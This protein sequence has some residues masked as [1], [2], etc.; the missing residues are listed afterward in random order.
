MIKEHFVGFFKTSSTVAETLCTIILE[1]LDGLGLDYKSKLVGQCYDGAANMSG[2][3]NGLH[4]KIRNKAKKALYVHCYA[5]QLNLALQHSCIAIKPAR[6]CLDT[7][8]SLHSFIECSSK[9]HALFELI[10][11][12][13]LK[14]FFLNRNKINILN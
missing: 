1:A 4:K 6:N 5:H 10:Q 9:G 8:N 3:R 2:D 11:G 12:N 13:F 14:Q 7:L